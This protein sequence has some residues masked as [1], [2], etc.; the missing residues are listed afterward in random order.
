MNCKRLLI[1]FL[2][3]LS[4]QIHTSLGQ[5]LNANMKYA[6]FYSPEIG[7]YVETYLLINGTTVTYRPNENNKMQGA[8][9]LLIIFQHNDTIANFS[10]I[11]LQSPEIDTINNNV[12]D[13][14]DYQRFPLPNGSYEMIV[15]ISD[16]AYPEKEFE[17]K[18]SITIDYHKDIIYISGI[19][20]LNSYTKTNDESSV[21][22]KNGYQLLP[23]ISNFYPETDNKLSF[24]CEFY[25][26]SK[27]IESGSP[28]LVNFYI[29]GFESQQQLTN[30][31]GFKRMNAAEVNV[32]LNNID[33]SRLASGNYELVVE[34]KDRNNQLLA[35]NILFFQRSNPNIQ[36]DTESL[37]ELQIANSFVAQYHN[38]DTLRQFVAFIYPKAT[39]LEKQFIF[40]K[41]KESD[42]ETLQRFFYN[43]WTERDPIHPHEAWLAYKKMVDIVNHE[44]KAVGMM[45]FQTDR[46]R[47]YL[48]YGPPNTIVDREFDAGSSGLG[49]NDDGTEANDGGTVPYQIWHY[50]QLSDN[51]RNKRF[52]F[53]NPHLAA[54]TYDLIHS[55]ANGELYNPQWQSELQRQI[56]KSTTIDENDKFK[57]ESG[58]FYNVPY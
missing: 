50:Y 9:N 11:Q 23:K 46:G 37:A 16:A 12:Y 17:Y 51:Q 33:I 26:V 10:K 52:V 35:K 42:I 47:V 15:R 49:I 48:Q 21:T 31:S 43:F 19:E 34:L 18:E 28:F 57:G 3:L 58:E 53:S 40:R 44:Y 6:I 41:A 8:V 56:F 32:M 45:G 24:Y 4:C 27:K 1:I 5:S 7:P 25:N 55:D 54:N 39:S 2:A 30:F 29:R 36:F 14:M 22:T 20:L 38:I 13:F